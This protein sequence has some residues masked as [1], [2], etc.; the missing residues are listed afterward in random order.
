[1]KLQ[2]YFLILLIPVTYSCSSWVA[3]NSSYEDDVYASS[4]A[5][6]SETTISEEKETYNT[7]TAYVEESASADTIIENNDQVT[8]GQECQY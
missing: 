3:V 4:D 2:F 8:Q 1:M 6:Q 7:S 5:P